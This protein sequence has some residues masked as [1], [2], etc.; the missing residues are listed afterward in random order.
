MRVTEIQAEPEQKR[1]GRSA[2]HAE[3]QGR[4]RPRGPI[5]PITAAG[6]TADAVRGV[7][8]LLS[9]QVQAI[10]KSNGKAPGE[11]RQIYILQF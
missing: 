3:N 2:R 5:R 1:Q 11:C 10:R 8:Y 4:W 9:K 7:K 6:T